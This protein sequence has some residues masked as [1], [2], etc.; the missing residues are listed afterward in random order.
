LISA[1]RHA[2]NSSVSIRSRPVIRSVADSILEWEGQNCLVLFVR[3]DE[4]LVILHLPDEE[5]VAHD[6]AS[7]YRR[8]LPHR[9]LLGLQLPWR[10]PAAV[11]TLI[12]RPD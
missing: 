4:C 6:L 2:G 9:I 11:M 8:L 1:T 5:L 12:C 3:D 7:G 10:R